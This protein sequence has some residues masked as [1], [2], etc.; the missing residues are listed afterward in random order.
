MPCIMVR[1]IQENTVYIPV[2]FAMPVINK[3]ADDNFYS[4]IKRI[5]PG[6][7]YLLLFEGI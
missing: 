1:V 7:N 6:K 3:V 4:S 5:E 2:N